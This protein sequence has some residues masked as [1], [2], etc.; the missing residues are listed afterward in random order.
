MRVKIRFP[1]L[2]SSA[3]GPAD[4]RP[5]IESRNRIQG[6]KLTGCKPTKRLA[7]ELPDNEIN[8]HTVL[9]ESCGVQSAGVPTAS[10]TG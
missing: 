10:T 8:E 9:P 6:V 2:R 4:S 5:S 3:E 7:I 1:D